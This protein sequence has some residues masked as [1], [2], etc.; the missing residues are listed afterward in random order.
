MSNKVRQIPTCPVIFRHPLLPHPAGLRNRVPREVGNVETLH[1]RL[2][3]GNKG[4]RYSACQDPVGNDE[5]YG[6]S[7]GRTAGICRGFTRYQC[8]IFR[9]VG[10]LV[11]RCHRFRSLFARAEPGTD[12]TFGRATDDRRYRPR[13][14]DPEHVGLLGC[15]L[16]GFLFGIIADYIRRVR[17]P[18]LSIPIYS[19]FT[20]LQGLSHS[21]LELGIYRFF[22][23]VGTGAEIIVGIPLVAEAFAEIHRAKILGVMMTGGAMGSIIGGQVYALIGGFG[24]RY[25]FLCRHRLGIAAVT[26]P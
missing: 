23:G 8:G 15:S 1:S 25:V 7:D 14:R 4:M 5:G 13:G 2:D 17:T 22:A 18:A 3:L 6:G 11:A 26:D 9:S 12:R 24:W 16:G 21:P 20:G 10:G 19:V